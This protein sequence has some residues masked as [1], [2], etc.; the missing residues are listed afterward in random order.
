M[1]EQIAI[2]DSV[3]CAQCGK[4]A[5]KDKREHFLPVPISPAVFKPHFPIPGV[6]LSSRVRRLSIMSEVVEN[7]AVSS[8]YVPQ[9]SAPTQF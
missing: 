2:F 9:G 1:P 6:M 3:H 7:P 8:Q 4:K 5:N